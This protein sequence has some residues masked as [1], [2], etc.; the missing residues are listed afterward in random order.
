MQVLLKSVKVI[1]PAS[2]LHQSTTDILIKDGYISDISQNIPTPN[3]ETETINQAGLCVSVGWLDMNAWIGDP[4]FE[5]KEDLQSAALAAVKGGF[6]EVAC[7]PNVEP[8]HQTKNSIGYIQNR[9]RI[10]PVS[11]Y[12]LGAITMNAQGKELTEMI[13]LHV[14]GAIAFTDGLQPVQQADVLVKA[15]QYVQFFDGLLIQKP[16]NSSLTQHGLMHEGIMS[17]QLGLKGMPSLAEEV[18]VTRDIKLLKY[19]GG[20]LHF[21][22]I[23]SAEAVELIREAKREGLNIT[24]DMAAFQT[25]F[26]DEEILPFDTNY[27]V[28]PPFRSQRDREALLQGL[29]DGTIDALVSA[30]RPQD[31][32]SKNLEFDLAE[33]G[34]TSLET[35]FAVANTYLSPVIGLEQVITKLAFAPRNI[36]KKEI[37]AIKVGEVANLTLFNPNQTWIPSESSTASKSKNNPFFDHTLQGQVFGIVNKNQLVLNPDY[38]L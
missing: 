10:L 7:L 22:L 29:A 6:T 32:E 33:F 17:T 4:G 12:S 31:T 25:A 5:H 3:S 13:D 28:N 15:L 35:A 24:C 37:P 16:E 8:V 23:S 27:K 26:T 21:T 9:S 1:A 20:R 2:K 34:I 14:A 38:T 11:F 30:H 36:L 19:T 18:V